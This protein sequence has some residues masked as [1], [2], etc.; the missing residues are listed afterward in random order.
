MTLA[1]Y[2][3]REPSTTEELNKLL[4]LNSLS[5]TRHG[6][7]E[8]NDF[9][10]AIL[11]V[12][13]LI[14]T[15]TY[16]AGLSPPGGYWQDDYAPDSDNGHTA[17][18]MTMSFNLALFFYICNGIAFFSSLYVIMV[19]IIG[20]PMWMVLYGSIGALGMANYASFSNTF[21]TSNG[22]FQ[23]I[24]V[25][26]VPF[27]Y[28]VITGFLL[29]PPFFAFISHRRRQ[30]QVDFPARLQLSSEAIVL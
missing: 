11:V 8:S 13:V 27:V 15:A 21:P 30:Q 4:G 9:R 7:Q 6:S 20:L 10:N 24:A 25:S 2:L 3:S 28:P 26:L 14:V 18:Q 1:G 12:A 19:L 23:D 29:S 5:K 17:G 22:S 16:Q